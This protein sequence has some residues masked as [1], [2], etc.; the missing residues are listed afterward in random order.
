[1]SLGPETQS[2]VVEHLN[3]DSKCWSVPSCSIRWYIIHDI[4]VC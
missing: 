4:S 1:M 2:L 3:L